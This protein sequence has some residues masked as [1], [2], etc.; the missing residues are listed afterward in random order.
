MIP[1]DRISALDGDA[2]EMM[3]QLVTKRRKHKIINN[4]IDRGEGSG[5]INLDLKAV[6]R[7][8]SW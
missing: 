8:H 3:E 4:C 1:Y 6:E 7:K 2:E 5:R